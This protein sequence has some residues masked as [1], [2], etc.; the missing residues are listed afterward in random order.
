MY[1]YISQNVNV[2]LDIVTY[3]I[4]ATFEMYMRCHF[5]FIEGGVPHY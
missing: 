2:R 3:S 4:Y 1:D 5:C